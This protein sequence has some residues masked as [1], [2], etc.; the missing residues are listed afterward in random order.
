MNEV[1]RRLEVHADDGVP[2]LF[3]HAQHESVF[4]DACVVDEDVDC[5]EVFFD[6]LHERFRLD[7]VCGVAGIALALDAERCYFGLGL[8]VDGKVCECDVGAFSGEFQ[9]NGLANAP[10]S[11]GDER[12]LS[13]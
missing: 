7:E 2:L 13:L 10:C 6:L 12:C 11:A 5:A 8:L 4:G 9:G 3:G 1:E